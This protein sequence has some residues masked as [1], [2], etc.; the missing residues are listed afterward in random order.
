MADIR[1]LW[2]EVLEAVKAKR[3]FA[4]IVL[5]QHAQVIAIDDHALTLGLGNAG[6]RESFARSGSDEILRQA[7]IDTI[8]VNRR[9]EAVVDP[10]TDPGTGATPPNLFLKQ[11]SNPTKKKKK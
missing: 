8:G 7:M 2:P 6:A 3:R 9:V 4:W 5:S 10:S 1:R 11:I